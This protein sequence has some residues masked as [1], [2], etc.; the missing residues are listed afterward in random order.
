METTN[1]KLKAIL[2]QYN[3]ELE[4]CSHLTGFA[5]VQATFDAVNRKRE[6][7]RKL[8]EEDKKESK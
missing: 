7:I 1:G 4:A 8:L 2:D 6:A 3:K 5:L